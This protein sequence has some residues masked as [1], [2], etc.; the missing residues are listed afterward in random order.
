MY[1]KYVAV[2]ND[3]VSR[4]D[5][6]QFKSHPDYTGILEHVSYDYGFEYLHNILKNT[7]ITYKDIQEFCAKNDRV[8]SPKLQ[9]YPKLKVSPSSLRY[10]YHA[11]LILNYLKAQNKPSHDIVE[12]GGGYGGLFLAIDHFA[13]LYDVKINSYAI[14][15]LPEVIKLQELVLSSFKTEL[16][17]PY[18][19][20][21]SYTYGLLVHKE[22]LFLI[23]NY[24]FSALDKQDR[25]KYVKFL[26]PKVE[27]GFMAWNFIPVYDFGFQMNVESEVP[28]TGPAATNRYVYF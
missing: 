15:D 14:I 6:S 19:L 2:V 26:M 27:H 13:K 10:I 23:S 11:H 20:H 9:T 24:C 18:T 12:V 21:P 8:G 16:Q 1:E 3:A 7:K 22:N 17:I 4:A 25:D 5:I 28:L